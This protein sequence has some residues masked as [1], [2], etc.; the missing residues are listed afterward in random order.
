MQM[1]D[2]QL[3]SSVADLIKMQT[4]VPVV[5]RVVLLSQNYYSVSKIRG[6][7]DSRD[8]VRHL[9]T[10]SIPCRPFSNAASILKQSC[11]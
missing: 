9:P 2:V 7:I 4:R 5:S 8:R 3:F 11:R 6:T 10:F 1:N